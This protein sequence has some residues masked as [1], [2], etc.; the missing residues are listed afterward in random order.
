VINGKGRIH[1]DISRGD[2]FEPEDA[3]LR[4]INDVVPAAELV[5]VK[6]QVEFVR[7]R[8]RNADFPEHLYDLLA[9]VVDV[10]R[11]CHGGEIFAS[12]NIQ[13]GDSVEIEG[14]LRMNARPPTW[15]KILRLRINGVSKQS[16]GDGQMLNVHFDRLAIPL[17]ENGGCGFEGSLDVRHGL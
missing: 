4:V 13:P 3:S 1:S 16:S 12:H 5:L 17:G 14:T 9:P 11:S 10:A 7:I 2:G 6:L 15:W 8:E